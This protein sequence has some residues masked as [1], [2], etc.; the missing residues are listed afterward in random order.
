MIKKNII[1]YIEYNKL[2][3]DTWYCLEFPEENIYEWIL[4]VVMK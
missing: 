3:N 4:E 1:N 2:Y